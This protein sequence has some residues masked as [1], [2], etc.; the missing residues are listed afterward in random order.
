MF[1]DP[2]GIFKGSLQVWWIIMGSLV[3]WLHIGHTFFIGL[4]VLSF[5]KG[6]TLL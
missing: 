4:L 5:L 6:T 1:R 3:S 2:K